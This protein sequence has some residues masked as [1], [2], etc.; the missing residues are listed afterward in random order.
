MTAPPL[1]PAALRGPV[2]DES[3]FADPM[4]FA[5]MRA[6]GA[7][8][9]VRREACMSLLRVQRREGP[10]DLRSCGLVYLGTP[11][12]KFPD[13]IEAAWVEA[14]RLT[15]RL[16]KAG[17]KVHSPIAA[18]HG[19]AIHGG[20]EPL[21]HSIWL[22]FDEVMMAVC[23]VCLVAEMEGW[24]RSFG[25]AH[26][27]AWFTAANKPV[28]YLDPDRLIARATPGAVTLRLRPQEPA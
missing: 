8:Q 22:P 18:T 4:D 15:A 16:M 28:I 24:Q 20:I 13:G 7:G 17:V 14:C 19:V 5:A 12:T 27:I 23:D 2:Q 10:L 11:Y 6:V 25:V 3:A 1:A 21:D 9:A 26:E